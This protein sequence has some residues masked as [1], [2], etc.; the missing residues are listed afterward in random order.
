MDW[1]RPLS[2]VVLALVGAGVGGLLASVGTTNRLFL[3]TQWATP[4]LA[5]V[6]LVVAVVVAFAALGRPWRWQL[7]TAYW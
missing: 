7:S 2:I 1:S 4:A 6:G 3:A 5:S